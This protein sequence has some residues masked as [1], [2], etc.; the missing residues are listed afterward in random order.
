MVTESV[1]SIFVSKILP[2]FVE[3][4]LLQSSYSVVFLSS[5][6]VEALCEIPRRTNDKLETLF[7]EP[8]KV[9][10][11]FWRIEQVRNIAENQSQP[12]PLQTQIE[13]DV[14]TWRNL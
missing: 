3:H 14:H 6:I 8:C 5:N 10:E 12:S 1:Y 2:Y 9:L 13:E 7:K 4:F 11:I